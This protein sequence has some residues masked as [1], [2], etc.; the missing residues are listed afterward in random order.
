MKSSRELN[1]ESERDFQA[2]L[3]SE[4]PADIRRRLD[5]RSP[6]T[7]TSHRK[8]AY[9]RTQYSHLPLIAPLLD[10]LQSDRLHKMWNSTRLYQFHWGFSKLRVR[11][12]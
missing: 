4:V 2:F 5:P 11:Y 8:L 12:R 1:E 10:A 9:V 3:A 6:S 7:R